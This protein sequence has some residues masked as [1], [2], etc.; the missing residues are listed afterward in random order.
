MDSLG[1]GGGGGVGGR[2]RYS[3]GSANILSVDLL[4]DIHLTH[5]AIFQ[6]LYLML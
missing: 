5:T 3:E 2:K 1:F 6:N 4:Y